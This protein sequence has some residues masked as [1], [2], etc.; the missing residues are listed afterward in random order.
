VETIS[1]ALV[2]AGMD[3]LRN[4]LILTALKEIF[5]GGRDDAIFSRKTLWLHCSAVSLCA[6]MISEQIFGNKGENAFLCGILHDIGLIV[7]DQIIP[8]SFRHMCETSS[9]EKNL[10]DHERETIGTDHCDIGFWLARE[11]KLPGIVQIGI[12]DHHKISK[13]IRPESLAGIIQIAEYLTSKSGYGSGIK[14]MD[15]LSEPLLMHIRENLPE[16]KLI[17][18][19]LPEELNRAKE[20]YDIEDS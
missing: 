5:S 19:E 16:Y 13:D 6:Q 9:S 11:W 4:M 14:H 3:N 10:V 2:F 17:T 1:E 7:E 8:D 18:R 20:L 12:R 15:S